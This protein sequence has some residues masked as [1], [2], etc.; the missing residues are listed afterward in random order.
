MPAVDR[1]ILRIGA[2]EL[3]YV[4]DVPDAV[5]VSEAVKLARE[6]STTSRRGSS[7]DCWPVSSSSSRPWRVDQAQ[8]ARLS[9]RY[10]VGLTASV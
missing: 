1:N 9:R 2:F 10:R 8:S 3:L 7:T 5:A 6:L 4:E